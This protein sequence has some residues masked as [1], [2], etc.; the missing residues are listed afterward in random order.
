MTYRHT[1]AAYPDPCPWIAQLSPE[2]R[3][4]RTDHCMGHGD[5]CAKRCYRKALA[6]KYARQDALRA[7]GGGPR[8][9]PA[10]RGQHYGQRGWCSWCDG[11]ITTKNAS[12]RGWHDGR[13]GEP[14]C[15]REF[16]LHTRPAEQRAFVIERDGERC[17]DCREVPLK[18][19][20]GPGDSGLYTTFPYDWRDWFSPG[21][22]VGSRLK[23]AGDKKAKRR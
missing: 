20:R 12:R 11:E 6:D 17:W 2:E 13:D 1:P 22:P 15:L 4:E 9:F 10:P 21:A 3:G 19:L 5:H 23:G 16:Y 14:D 18:V 8:A 7:R